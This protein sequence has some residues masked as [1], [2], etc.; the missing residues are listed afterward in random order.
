MVISSPPNLKT[1]SHQWCSVKTES[2]REMAV[3]LSIGPSR[4]PV[5]LMRYD[6]ET[7]HDL[8]IKSKHIQTNFSN[9]ILNVCSLLADSPST[10]ICH[11]RAEVELK[12]YLQK[13]ILCFL[14]MKKCLNHRNEGWRVGSFHCHTR[15][16]CAHSMP[17]MWLRPWLSEK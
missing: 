14:I 9:L 15:R 8:I 12:D 13:L 2:K 11:S 7:S 1:A 5:P 6:G 17:A 3:I 16:S 10:Y 4:E